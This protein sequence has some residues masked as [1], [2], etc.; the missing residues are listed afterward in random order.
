[1]NYNFKLML[2]NATG[3]RKKIELLKS[4][5]I[6]KGIDFCFVTETWIKK[7]A[8][9]TPKGLVAISSADESSIRG[10][11]GTAFMVNE[12]KWNG[13]IKVIEVDNIRGLYSFIEIGNVILIAVYFPPSM[14]KE[15][16]LNLLVCLIDKA[17][18]LGKHNVIIGGDFNCEI[19]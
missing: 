19:E 13:K 10:Q 9:S 18:N 16:V 1:M 5:M 14:E 7:E 3:I 11:A 4:Y 2:Y 12:D 15:D 17:D 8:L 6:R